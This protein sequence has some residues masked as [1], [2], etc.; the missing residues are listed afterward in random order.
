[1]LLWEGRSEDVPGAMGTYRGERRRA[2]R[3]GHH[4]KYDPCFLGCFAFCLETL[5]VSR[6]LSKNNPAQGRVRERFYY[7][8]L[9]CKSG[10]LRNGP[11]S[12]TTSPAPADLSEA[13]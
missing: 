3:G 7:V 6:D 10:M 4:L 9:T 5:K 8:L 2:S 13:E 11:T 12:V 1:M